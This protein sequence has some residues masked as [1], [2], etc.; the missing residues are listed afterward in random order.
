MSMAVDIRKTVTQQRSYFQCG[1]TRSVVFRR[2]ELDKLFN[3]VKEFEPEIIAALKADLGKSEFEAF[4]T[5]VGMVLD[6]I[7]FMRRHVAKFSARKRVGVS[8]NNFPAKGY[9]YPEPYGSVLIFSAWNY[10]FQL[11]MGPLAAAIAAGNCVV[12]KPAEQA[13][14]TAEIIQKIITR[15]FEPQYIA[16]FP[17]SVHIAQELL[18]EKFDYIFFTGSSSV[19][20][21]VMHAAANSLTPVTLEL[22]GK[23]P[24]IVDADA[25]IDLAA[26]RIVWGKFLNAGQT[27]V[28]PDYLYVHT[29]V[30]TPLLEKMKYYIR[31]FYGEDPA[32][33]PDYPKIVN[34][35][36]FNRLTGLMNC[37]QIV[38]GG[39]KD[40]SR[41]YIAPTIIDGIN[42]KDQIMQ[43]EIFGPILPVMQFDEIHAVIDFINLRPKPL[44]LYYFS[45]SR[46]NKNLLIA[47]TQAGGMCVNETVTHLINSSMPF[48]GVGESGMGAYHGK[49]GFA[50]F[51]HYKPVMVKSTLLDIPLRYPPFSD[52]KL[53][54]LR[55]LSK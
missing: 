23:S 7:A 19:G 9:I 49:A 38:C 8:I 37:G 17:G 25:D 51:T 28:A 3:A 53:K 2:A 5:E 22:G 36:H 16:I 14:A 15:L 1:F 35:K 10:P 24:C 44:A 40:L 18:A 27:C 52:L 33:C 39:E 46:I 47:R 48:G 20:K 21:A 42:P 11:M 29:S 13:P 6:D 12:L 31:E 26:K 55:L 34:E 54:I 50:A 43:E 45:S 32:A 30:K 4:A 41:R